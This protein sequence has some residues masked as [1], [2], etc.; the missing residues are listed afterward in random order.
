MKGKIFFMVVLCIFLTGML[1]GCVEEENEEENKS[2]TC[3]LTANPT[4]GTAPLTV[5]F[6]IT[7]SDSDGSISSW[8]LDIDNDGL[9][10]YHG[11]GNPPATQMHT[12]EMSGSFTAKLYVTDNEGALC[13][14]TVEVSVSGPQYITVTINNNMDYGAAVIIFDGKGTAQTMIYSKYIDWGETEVFHTNLTGS[15]DFKVMV[16][17]SQYG[18]QSSDTITT[19]K[20]FVVTIE[21]Y[22]TINITSNG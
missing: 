9:V 18:F 8:E 19:D 7:A 20:H 5:T 15:H 16:T 11:M 14:K 13:I 17:E 3:A 4:S 2:P 22:G 6:T 12:Y 1:C 21:E 10:E